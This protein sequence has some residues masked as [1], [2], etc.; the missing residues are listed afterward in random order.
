M[1]YAPEWQDKIPTVHERSKRGGKAL[2]LFFVLRGAVVLY[3]L[4]F[5]LTT[6]ATTN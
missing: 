1:E 6:R 4:P 3:F 5:P 2:L